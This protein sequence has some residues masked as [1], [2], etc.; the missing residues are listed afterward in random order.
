MITLRGLAYRLLQAVAL[1]AIWLSAGGCSGGTEIP[2]EVREQMELKA[3]AAQ[4]AGDASLYFDEEVLAG[5]PDPLSA[6]ISYLRADPNV[7]E[8]ELS[9]DGATVMAVLFNDERIAVMTDEKNRDEWQTVTNGQIVPL[10]QQKP[11]WGPT[12]WKAG[13]RFSQGFDEL[14]PILKSDS[15]ICDEATFPQ[16][17]EACLIMNFQSE[18]QQDVSRISD[19]LSRAGYNVKNL[20]LKTVADVRN[21]RETLAECGVIYMSSHGNVRKNMAGQY[22]NV[23]TTEIEL[24][25]KN[26]G[27]FASDL[28]DLIELF[29]ADLMDQVSIDAHKGKAY[30]S[31][32]PAFFA[33]I[34]YRNSFVYVDACNSDKDVPEGGSRLRQAFQANGAGAFIGWSGPISTRFS[35]PAAE[36]IFDGLAPKVAGISAVNVTVSPSDP[37]PRESY[38]PTAA[39]SP[40]LDGVPVKISVSGTDDFSFSESLLTDASG[41][42]VFSVIPGG[43]GEVVDTITVVAGGADNTATV[44]NVVQNDPTLA[45]VWKLPWNPAQESL[46]SLTSTAVDNYNLICN[47]LDVT[48]T[49][50]VIKF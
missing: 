36:A 37:G 46:S 40:A 9:I 27:K 19:P 42:A 16:S 3:A 49:T 30:W 14:A 2:A 21:L 24:D 32:T 48:E 34:S 41:M 10:L 7:R 28:V 26:E 44:V 8:V 11:R 35:N 13:D 1:F 47:N 39:I 33:S 45:G 20:S 5:N 4:S 6:L 25:F 38:V 43:E 18:F 22:G 12:V 29:G 17:K 31:L 15:I 50:T 23:V